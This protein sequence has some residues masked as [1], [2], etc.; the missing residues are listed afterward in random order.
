MQRYPEPLAALKQVPWLKQGLGLHASPGGAIYRGEEINKMA[1]IL[2]IMHY[3]RDISA[4]LHFE[5]WHL[6]NLCL[7]VLCVV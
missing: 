7:F 5:N 1:S 6:E 3:S 4:I 2:P